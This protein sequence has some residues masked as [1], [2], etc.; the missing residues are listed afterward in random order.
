M[1]E[2]RTA[3]NSNILDKYAFVIALIVITAFLLYFGLMI[4]VD[5]APDYNGL[6]TVSATLGNIVAAIIGYYFGQRPIRK[7]AMDAEAAASERDLF[8]QDSAENLDSAE[9]KAQEIEEYKTQLKDMTQQL[10]A[11]KNVIEYLK[12]RLARL[13]YG[14]S[15][16]REKTEYK[17]GSPFIN[18]NSAEFVS[19]AEFAR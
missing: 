16:T 9:K 7:L 12:T 1:A 8:R 13:E 15:R 5:G 6:K 3:S 11:I 2:E 19:S 17:P 18:F 4:F 10:N 14:R